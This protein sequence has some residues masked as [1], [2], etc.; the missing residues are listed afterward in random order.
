[1]R[2]EIIYFIKIISVTTEFI[3]GSNLAIDFFRQLKNI[4]WVNGNKN[5]LIFLKKCFNFFGDFKYFKVFLHTIAL[6]IP[7]DPV[8]KTE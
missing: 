2:V 6:N 7:R 8:T 1:M 4:E 3:N 5:I